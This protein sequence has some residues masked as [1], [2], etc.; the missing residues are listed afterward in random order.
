MRPVP[1]WGAPPLRP[2]RATRHLGASLHHIKMRLSPKPQV[3][4]ALFS[5]HGVTWGWANARQLNA[6]VQISPPGPG[7]PTASLPAGAG[8][9]MSAIASKGLRYMMAGFSYGLLPD[10]S[11]VGASCLISSIFSGL[12]I[13]SPPKFVYSR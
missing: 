13:L 4:R 6:T 9:Q 5:I 7:K 2:R 8:S 12:C 10:C 11:P 3:T 1:H